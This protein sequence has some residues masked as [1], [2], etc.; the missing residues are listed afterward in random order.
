MSTFDPRKSTTKISIS[1]TDAECGVLNKKLQCSPERLSCPYSLLYGDGSSTAGYYLNDV[2]TFNQ[3]P[4]DNSTAK[5]GTARLV[6]GSAS[7]TLLI[8]KWLLYF[9]EFRDYYMDPYDS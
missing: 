2:F 7:L 8:L 3:V 5:S 9:W 4:S 1:C 6:F